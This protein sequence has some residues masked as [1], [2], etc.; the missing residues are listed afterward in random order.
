MWE[1]FEQGTNDQQ[2][3]EQPLAKPFSY[4]KVWYPRQSN[5]HINKPWL[6]LRLANHNTA[7]VRPLHSSQLITPSEAVSFVVRSAF[8]VEPVS[9]LNYIRQAEEGFVLGKIILPEE[10]KLEYQQELLT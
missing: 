9:G 10:I 8:K 5:Q 3:T 7:D 1:L 6:R 4:W 2:L